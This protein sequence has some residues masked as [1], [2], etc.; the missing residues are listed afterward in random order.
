MDRARKDSQ[1]AVLFFCHLYGVGMV[2][3]TLLSGFGKEEV[4]HASYSG[5]ALTVFPTSPSVNIDSICGGELCVVI[6]FFDGVTGQC[7][8][9]RG[10]SQ[11]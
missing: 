10:G 11:V 1:E 7:G 5:C 6:L 3:R 4:G 9:G 2:E 8:A